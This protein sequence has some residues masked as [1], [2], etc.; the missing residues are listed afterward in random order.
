MCQIEGQHDMTGCF[1]SFRGSLRQLGRKVRLL[2][3]FGFPDPTNHFPPV[4]RRHRSHDPWPEGDYVAVVG[5]LTRQPV[6]PPVGTG[7]HLFHGGT[8]RHVGS[9]NLPPWLYELKVY[10]CCHERWAAPRSFPGG[11][12]KDATGATHRWLPSDWRVQPWNGLLRSR[13]LSAALY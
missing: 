8:L 12:P 4:C 11:L 13:S 7:G 6:Q 3:A 1:A 10:L 9:G 2:L 5:T